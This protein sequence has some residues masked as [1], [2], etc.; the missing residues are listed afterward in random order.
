MG[1]HYGENSVSEADRSANLARQQGVPEEA[2]L[3]EN[4]SLTIVDNVKSGFNYLDL[5]NI[6]YKSIIQ[7]MAW[8][9]QRRAWS[10][11]QKY[12]DEETQIIRVN[13]NI[14]N[15]DLQQNNWY[16]N[17]RSIELVFNEFVKMKYQI[18]LN[19]S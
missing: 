9:P 8:Y 13:A 7:I 4:K 2:I 1:P 16:K 5:L 18:I 19:S 14:V 10:T 15:P 12:S 11:I 17:Q 3:I 6:P